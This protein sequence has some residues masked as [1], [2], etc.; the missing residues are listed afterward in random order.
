MTCTE[1]IERSGICRQLRHRDST[2]IVIVVIDGMNSST[3]GCRIGRD[4][5]V[6]SCQP[7]DNYRVILIVGMS[8]SLIKSRD[9]ATTDASDD[10]R[11]HKRRSITASVCVAILILILK[12]LFSV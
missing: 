9:I 12:S 11:A 5:L 10:D 3:S 2:T 6:S 1:E 4:M 8:T 7:R